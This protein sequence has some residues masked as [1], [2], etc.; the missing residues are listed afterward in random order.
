M[1]RPAPR[2]SA[3]SAQSVV[4]PQPAKTSPAGP[5]TS[6]SLASA[7]RE[8]EKVT[9]RLP[10]ELVEQARAAYWTSAM[11]T[12]TRSFAAWVAQAIEAKLQMEQDAYNGG[13][14]FPSLPAGRIPTGRR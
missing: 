4:A 8:S 7:Q 14:P 3:L 10:R 1:T 2:R 13:E 11:H 6:A 9:L 12:G 5:A